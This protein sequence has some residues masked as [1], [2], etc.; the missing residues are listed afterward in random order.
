MG[1]LRGCNVY[2]IIA[3]KRVVIMAVLKNQG[4]LRKDTVNLKLHATVPI[5]SVLYWEREKILGLKIGRKNWFSDIMST[6]P[7]VTI[8]A[9]SNIQIRKLKR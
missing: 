4:W 2:V 9:H 3:R 1:D 5:Y 7:N 6:N 8:K